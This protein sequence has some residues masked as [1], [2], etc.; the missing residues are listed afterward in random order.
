MTRKLII[1]SGA[2]VIFVLL[3]LNQPMHA[4]AD[5]T[6]KQTIFSNMDGF[7]FTNDGCCPEVSTSLN[8]EIIMYTT[9]TMQLL[10]Q[11]GNI[12][13]GSTTYKLEFVPTNKT[14]KETV[15][16]DCE[17]STTY[18]QEGEISMVGD[19]GTKIKG[20]GEYS[21]EPI[22]AVLMI[23]IPLLTLVER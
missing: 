14:I 2:L 4:A 19:D 18:Q 3:V 7:A 16:N 15:S 21:W 17:S 22:P 10:Q 9:G 13:I 5:D 23:N 6:V 1:A 11:N 8:D 20:S 12:T